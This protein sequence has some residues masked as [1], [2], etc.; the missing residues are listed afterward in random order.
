[1]AIITL[2]TDFGLQDPYVAEMKGRILAAHADATVIDLTHEIPAG[3]V[4]Q[5]AWML[6]RSWS[7]FPA[8]TIHVAVIDPGVGSQRRGVAAR[9]HGHFFV[10][11]DNGLLHPVLAD[12]PESELREI[13]GIHRWEGGRGTTFDGRDLFA[14]LAGE[15]ARGM[16]FNKVGPPAGAPF[17]LE[18]FRL[19][20]QGGGWLA[21]I[22][23]VDRYGNLITCAAESFL[24]STFGEAWREIGIDSG[25]KEIRT[26]RA[27]YQ[28]VGPGELL[29]TIGSAGT[30]EISKNGGSAA[31]LLGLAAGDCVRI[32]SPR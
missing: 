9:A 8:R 10:G 32:E 7:A 17:L 5:G 27:A 3:A 19:S 20:P 13:G 18:P 31:Q 22:V 21:E 6:W 11:P 1:M 28:D 23:A 30:L 26:V 12:D 25:T 16:A 29:L 14:P 2:L 15:L 4:R 24:R